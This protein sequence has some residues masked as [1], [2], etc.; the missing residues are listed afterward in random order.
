MAKQNYFPTLCETLAAEN[1]TDSWDCFW[2]PIQYGET[3]SYNFEAA[4]GSI[5]H[6]SIYRSDSGS[7]ERPVHYEVCTAA[8]AKRHNVTA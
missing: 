2:S 7:Y 3:R 5:R 4:N 8:Y 6:V 1:L